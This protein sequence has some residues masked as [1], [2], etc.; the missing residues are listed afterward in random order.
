MT[1]HPGAWVEIDLRALAHNVERIRHLVGPAV[2]IYAVCKGDGYGCGAG[3]VAETAL[4]AGADALTVGDL[5]DAAAI[6]ARRINAPILLYGATDPASAAAVAELDLTATLHDVEGL[7]AFA[8]L[9]RPL[10]AFVKVDCGFGRLG[11]T[12]ESWPHIF[13]QIRRAPAL[14]LRG[15]YTHIGAV[16]D[17]AS[18]S[19]QAALFRQAVREAEA[20]GF[21]GLELMASSSR[22]LLGYADLHLSAVNPGRM[23]MGMLEGPWAALAQVLPV[24]RAI[25]SR[26]IQVKTVRPD[27]RIGYGGSTPAAETIRAAIIPM[28]FAAGLPRVLHGHVLVRG[29][30]APMVGLASMEHLMLDVTTIP[31]AA[32]G[33]EAV[34]LGRQGDD[35]ITADELSRTT[36]LELLE[37]VPRLARGLH[38]VYLR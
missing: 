17:A 10:E 13:G 21:T 30:R 6:R 4:K 9:G 31:G 7:Q 3:D 33:D 1:S 37:I 27:M 20:A 29:A 19:R 36:G 14:H 28:G 35:E 15:I 26:L 22:V 23:L 32:V 2:R 24:V 8:G 34:V 38:R 12:P 18:V 16:D 11:F 25:K 5:A